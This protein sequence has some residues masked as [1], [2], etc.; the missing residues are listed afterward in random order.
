[1]RVNKITMNEILCEIWEEFWPADIASKKTRREIRNNMLFVKIF[2]ITYFWNAFVSVTQFMSTPLV[3]GNDMLP[4]ASKY[5][6]SYAGM[7]T[8]ELF[9]VWQ[10]FSHYIVVVVLS[11]YDFLFSAVI[12]NCVAQFQ[13][14]QDVLKNIYLTDNPPLRKYMFDKLGVNEIKNG[15]SKEFQLLLKCIKHHIRLMM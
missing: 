13:I 12:M 14:L 11:G 15:R 8:Y 2:C 4:L 3:M 5:P 1:M 9:Y 10:Y 7:F 6:F